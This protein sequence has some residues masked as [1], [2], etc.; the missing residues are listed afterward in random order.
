MSLYIFV[1][2]DYGIQQ[3]RLNEICNKQYINCD[4]VQE[5]LN[6][7]KT[8]G[9]LS[10]TN[11]YVVKNDI[12]FLK[13][14][15][16]WN[17]KL[18]DNTLILIYDNISKYT[19]FKNKFKDNIE[20]L[21]HPDNNTIIKYL[22]KYKLNKQNINILI[23]LCKNDLSRINHEV[24]KIYNYAL[25]DNIDINKAFEKLY[26]HNFI[27]KEPDDA[28][29][30]FANA[31]LEKDSAKAYK[32]LQECYGVNE[33]DL[34]FISV[35]YK[36]FYK[37]FVI[38]NNGLPEKMSAK[39]VYYFKPYLNK[40]SNDEIINILKLLCDIDYKYKLGLIPQ[41]CAIEYIVSKILK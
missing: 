23:S 25:Y 37:L 39:A 1:T 41:D 38:Q 4:T 26:K 19:K 11:T 24:D 3:H 7:C 14:D 2:E 8:K 17:V 34:V 30:D 20:E 29:F 13:N 35:L 9:L 10:N 27:Y 31:I 5:A 32:L 12:D 18:N 15:K 6:R 16:L 22:N 33:N 36:Q 40:Y 21:K 28:I